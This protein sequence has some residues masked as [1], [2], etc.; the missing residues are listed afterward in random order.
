[1]WKSGR[2]SSKTMVQGSSEYVETKSVKL[3]IG[4]LAEC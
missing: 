3:K 2:L 1:M 4:M